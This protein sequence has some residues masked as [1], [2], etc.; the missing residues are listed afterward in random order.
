[1]RV[2]SSSVDVLRYKCFGG[3]DL[4]PG[5]TMRT[6]KRKLKLSH[7]LQFVLGRADFR[8]DKLLGGRATIGQ[9]SIASVQ[10]AFQSAI[11][12]SSPD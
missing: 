5:L 4:M 3:D 1:M 6:P 8:L 11:S 10:K 7:P 2:P 12:P 9:H